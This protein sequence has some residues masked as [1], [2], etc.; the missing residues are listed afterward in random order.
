MNGHRLCAR[1]RVR[2]FTCIISLS[3]ARPSEEGAVYY[4]SFPLTDEKAEGGEVGDSPQLVSCLR[5]SPGLPPATLGL[6]ASQG[7]S[8]RGEGGW[9]RLLLHVGAQ[10]PSSWHLSQAL[11]QTG[12]FSAACG[13]EHQML[14]LPSHHSPEVPGT[15]PSACPSCREAAEG[16][17]LQQST[18][19]RAQKGLAAS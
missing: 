14:A 18:S 15:L 7:Q 11:V 12:L 19:P 10:S 9:G 13:S 4:C 6:H 16:R 3:S 2:R 8:G 17:R 5:P 1:C